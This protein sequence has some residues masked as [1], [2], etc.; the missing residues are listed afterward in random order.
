MAR[1]Q[2]GIDIGSRALHLVAWDGKYIRKPVVETLP[3]G[4]V[5]DGRIVSP[6][7]MAD[8]LKSVRKANHL[9]GGQASLVLHSNECFCRRIDVPAMT[10]QQL[11]VNLSYEFR[12]FITQ[13]KDKYFYDY[14]VLGTAEEGAKLDVMAAAV[15]K[16]TIAL[17]DD[18]LRKAGLKLKVA[19]PEEI[20][21]INLLNHFPSEQ[22]SQGSCCLLDLGHAAIS[23]HMLKNGQHQS[24]RNL[25]YGCAALDDVIAEHYH[26]APYVACGYRESNYEDCQNLPECKEIYG[27]MALEVLKAVNYYNYSNAEQPIEWICCW[28]G[29]LAMEPL[30][31]TL[32]STLTVPVEGWEALL[33]G[34]GQDPVSLLALGAA[35]QKE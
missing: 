21:Y 8:L 17:Y 26:V 29:G 28:G 11:K 31:E 9:G 3:E 7:A 19:V 23:L 27:H 15:T 32:R 13:E 25:D 24:G 22:A 2:L 20:A 10:H 35:L 16:E 6:P 14:A 5:R 33:P 18:M 12:D 4:L 34:L 30:L 1:G